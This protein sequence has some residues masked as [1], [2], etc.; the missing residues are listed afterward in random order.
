MEIFVAILLVLAVSA[1]V[2][3]FAIK[4]AEEDTTGNGGRD[5]REPRNNNEHPR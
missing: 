5:Q 4:G 1:I 3:F 2:Y